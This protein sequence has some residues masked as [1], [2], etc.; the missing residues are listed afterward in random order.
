MKNWSEILLKTIGIPSIMAQNVPNP[1]PEYYTCP[2]KKS[3]LEKFIGHDNQESYFTPT[4][5]HQVAY[6]ILATQA[7]GSREKA[8]VGI[9]RLI[10]EE[11]YNAAYAIHEGPYEVDEEDLK[12]PE[13][14]NPRQILYWYWARWGCWYRYQPLDHIRYYFGEKIGFYFAWLGVTYLEYWKRK[15][16][17]LAHRWD[18]LDYEI[19]EERPRPQYSAHCTQYAKNP[20]TDVLEPY[21]PPR[22]R[23]ARII[24][25]LICV[26]VMVMLVLVFIVAVIIYRF[27]I[28]IPLFQNK[29][30]RSNA[31]IYAT[32]S[33]AIVNLILIMCLG[34]V[35][36]T[37]AYKM[38]QWGKTHIYF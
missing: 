9:D 2:F 32:L 22:A 24:A 14:M 4:Q 34:K 7:Y 19:E 23:V 36:E 38:T 18:V 20:I 17:K 35:Y 29:L 3:K 10:Q 16:A 11:V 28:K 12:N 30:L 5:R 6:D 37:L 26:M 25:G 31:E 13:K 15:N 21:F 27:L 33:A 1:P 8:Q